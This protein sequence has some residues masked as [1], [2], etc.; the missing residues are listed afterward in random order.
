MLET[1][2]RNISPS[3]SEAL[4]LTAGLSGSERQLALHSTA[5]MCSCLEASGDRH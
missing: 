2:S 4:S 3:K 5:A 1:E